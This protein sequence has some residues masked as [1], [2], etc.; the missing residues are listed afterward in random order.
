MAIAF[1]KYP[2]WIYWLKEKEGKPIGISM[3][4]SKEGCI[5]KISRLKNKRGLKALS[6]VCYFNKET[7]MCWPR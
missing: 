2:V 3:E 1:L 7:L 6:S 4:N 5:G